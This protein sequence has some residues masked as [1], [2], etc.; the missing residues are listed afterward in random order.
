MSKK[1]ILGLVSGLA[2]GVALTL[3]LKHRGEIKYSDDGIYDPDQEL[4]SANKFLS[5]AKKKAEDLVSSAKERSGVLLD[6]AN[7][8]LKNA[9]ERV[10]SFDEDKISVKIEKL[11][12]IKDKIDQKIEE[13]IEK[14]NDKLSGDNK[15]E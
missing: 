3:I 8:I 12:S 11:N 2:A 1:L 10:K 15:P 7:E 6:E 9:K 14:L 13:K 4:D 5:T